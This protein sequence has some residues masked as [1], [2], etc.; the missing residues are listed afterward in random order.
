MTLLSIA[1]LLFAAVLHA[2]WNLLAKR[3]RDNQVFLIS[4]AISAAVFI[5]PFAATRGAS[6]PSGAW[7]I[8]V[9]SGVLEALYYLLLGLAYRGGDL[10][11]V[12]PISRGSSPLFVAVFAL[13][14]QGERIALIGAVGIALTVVGI[15]VVHLKSFAPQALLEPVRA[16]ATS[17]T[18]QL[19]LLTGA[20]IA[21]YSVVDKKGVGQMDP[22][23][24]F[25]LV[26]VVS[27][28][29]LVP[30]VL[31]Q[32]REALITEWRLNWLTILIVGALIGGGYLLILFI[33]ANNKVSYATSVRTASVVF[34]AALG[35]IVLKE[36]LGDKKI[37]GAC[38]IFA[39]IICIGLAQ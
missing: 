11:F 39:G 30:Y 2:I 16:I 36:P 17:R 3:G 38:V 33:L 5:A 31:T 14:W 12:Y 13:A 8:I 22:V 10:S 19:A 4:A 26:L 35:A 20:T 9:A 18:S 32:K 29:L 21:G 1:A 15:Y 25:F 6:V 27:T 24:Y 23:L 7:I 34:G 28:V 37:L